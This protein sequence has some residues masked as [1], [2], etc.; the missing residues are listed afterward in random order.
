MRP[1]LAAI[2]AAAT[3]LPA[4]AADKD[5]FDFAA[6]KAAPK[7]VKKIVFVADTGSHGARGNHEFLAGAMLLARAINAA[8]PDSA[9]AVVHTKDHWPKDLS[10]ADAVIVLLNHGGSAVNPAI[11]AAVDRGAGFMGIHYAVEVN[12]GEQGDAFLKWMGG[13]FETFWS[14]NP[15]WTPEFKSLPEHP[16]TRGVKP[17]RVTDEW[18]YHMRFVEGM[19]GVTPIL[20]AVPP[21]STLHGKGPSERGNNPAVAAEVA[22]GKPQ[23]L[24]WAYERPNGGGRGFGFT[25]L[26]VHANLADDNFRTLLLNAVAWVSGL[27][28]PAGGVPSEKPTA[29]QLDQLI[30]EG[31]KAAK[32]YGI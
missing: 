32:E 14:V 24:A 15:F 27:Q 22:A 23:H 1:V 2:L 7:S 26:H 8:Y 25:G 20:S 12:K 18:Y 30:D 4:A 31:H 19:A 6:Q 17:F 13:Y 3:A 21:P 5:V 16:V 9:Y 10:H 11:R 29:Q 28:V